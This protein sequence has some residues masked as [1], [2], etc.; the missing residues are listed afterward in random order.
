MS[1]PAVDVVLLDLGNVVLKLKTQALIRDL[2]TECAGLTE[3]ALLAELRAPDSLHIRYE[4]GQASFDD[5][6]NH[7]AGRWGLSWTR[8]RFLSRWNDYFLP[9]R[10]M[11]V[12]I[13]KIR[14]QTRLWA[15]SNTNQDHLAWVKR[16]FR[17][18]DVFE[19]V[20]A[21]NEVGLRKPDPEIYRKSLEIIGVDAQRILFVDDL[22][23]NIAAAETLGFKTFHYRFNDFEFKETL[24]RLGFDL[25]TTDHRPSPMA[26]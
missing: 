7:F 21:S 12:L 9:N 11:E 5:F 22:D 18:M 8:E 1:G 19:G 3:E 17:V 23:K 4:K 20:V 6:F 25:P 26:C 16:V 15:L 14:D 2:E 13:S 10:P 24:E